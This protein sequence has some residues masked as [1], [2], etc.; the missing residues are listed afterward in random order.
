M[1]LYISKEEVNSGRQ[2]EFDYAKT[3]AIIFMVLIH[4]WEELTKINIQVMPEGFMHNMFQFGAGPLAAP[5]FMFS[6]GVGMMYSSHT[7]PKEL[8]R[9]GIN[10]FITAYL[11]NFFRSGLL[12]FICG[13]A[14]K[15]FDARMFIYINL[16]GDILQ[17]AGLSFML[18]AL[19]KKLKL[20]VLHM[21][22]IAFIMQIAGAYLATLFT[23]EGNI[24]YLLGLFFKT[25]E[26][27]FPLLQWF[28]YPCAGMLYANYL[29]HINNK[30]AFYKIIFC[31][32]SVIFISYGISLHFNNYDL[33]LI[34]ALAG[35]V[36]YNQDFIK[37]SFILL[38]L[39]I[40]L[41][42]FFMIFCKTTYKALDVFAGF[43]SK[44]LNTIYIVQWLLVGWTGILSGGNAFKPAVSI[45]LGFAYIALAFIITKIYIGIK[46][47]SIQKK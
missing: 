16:N 39:L 1:E 29:K 40:E 41:S 13:M 24:K 45:P 27:D 15:Q 6:M 12:Y 36:Y 23:P 38:V 10:L 8:F 4:V 9:R 22:G 21:T 33:K 19:L 42:A 47:G 46:K 28:I 2:K 18:V 44:N 11:L 35:D 43:A 5:M 30:D 31:V 34:Y 37:T 17:F 32:C 25:P 14:K 3:V 7:T 20:H 26:M